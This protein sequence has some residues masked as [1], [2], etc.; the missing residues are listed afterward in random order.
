MRPLSFWC[1]EVPGIGSFLAVVGVCG[2]VM[3]AGCVFLCGL[4]IG[5]PL[6]CSLSIC[7]FIMR[8]FGKVSCAFVVLAEVNFHYS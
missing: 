4:L 5:E 1:M 8:K 3:G 6:V 7:G 2:L